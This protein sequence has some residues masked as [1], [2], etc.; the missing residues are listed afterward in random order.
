MEYKDNEHFVECKKVEANNSIASDSFYV[1]CLKTAK[2]M[3][4]LSK[5]YAKDDENKRCKYFNYCANDAV[6]NENNS[7]NETKF[8]SAYKDLTCELKICEEKFDYIDDIIFKRVKNLRDIYY[9]YKKFMNIIKSPDHKNCPDF[10]NCVNMYSTYIGT[11]ND[12]NQRDFCG[13]LQKFKIYLQD[14]IHIL[15]VMITT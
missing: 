15:S 11:F 7:H 1:T 9:E 14:M 12:Q 2:Y 6:R 3:K 13:A 4:E 10:K 5:V 8:M